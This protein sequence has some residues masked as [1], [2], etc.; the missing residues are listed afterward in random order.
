M[1]VSVADA[2][3]VHR[4]IAFAIIMFSGAANATIGTVKNVSGPVF[5]V[6]ESGSQRTLG[7]GDPLHQGEALITGS[8]SYAQ[9]AFS[10]KG[11]MTLRPD[12]R[13][14]IEHY[15]FVPERGSNSKVVFVLQKGS[16]RSVV[17][18]IRYFGAYELKAAYATV[19]GVS[20]A[21]ANFIATVVPAS[22]KEIEAPGQVKGLAAVFHVHVVDGS[23][24]LANEAG[25]QRLTAGES[26]LAG[27]AAEMP[28]LVVQR[29]DKDGHASPL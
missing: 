11:E 27:S 25:T 8:R 14:K 13:L 24:E 16:L 19:K 7:A 6:S 22:S 15:E 2:H 10:D 29:V 26:G 5:A 12:T 18:L 17:G 21:G 3:R 20:E 23:L 9:V 28:V 4:L 1:I